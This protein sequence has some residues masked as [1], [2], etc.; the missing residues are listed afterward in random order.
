[1]AK[2][3]D[4]GEFGLIDRIRARKAEHDED[5]V[6]GIGDDCAV[7]R[8]GPVLEVLTTDCLVE[9][10]HYEEGWL[11]MEDVGWKALAVNVSD[12]AAMGGIPK[13]AVVTLFL[14]L[15][16]TTKENDELY[17]GLDACGSATGVSIVGGDI[18]RTKGPFAISITLAGTCE[19]DEVVLR[20]GAREGDIIVV[21]GSLGEA[22]VGLNYLRG[23]KQPDPGSPGETCVAKFKRPV[24]RVAEARA[25]VKR[26]QPSSMID[27]SD[28]LVSDLWHI[29]EMSNAGAVLDAEAIPVGQGVLDF[30]DG[31]REEAL[32]SAVAGGEEYELLFTVDS[33]VEDRL[34]GLAAKIGTGLTSIGRITRKGSGVKMAGRD[35]EKPIEKSGFDHFKPA[36]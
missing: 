11:S 22:A 33:K 20:S 28:G 4:I 8:R 3:T 19:R 25:I 13:H 17:S 30:F 15:D 14:P 29:L 1:M 24:P 10:S 34:A 7:I 23:G 36:V 27:I 5:V 18:V 32:S 2:V 35:G 12:V 21:T 9:G 31:N 16:Y 6:V 26:L